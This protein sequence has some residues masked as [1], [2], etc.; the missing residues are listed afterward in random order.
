MNI[1][2][3][4]CTH[5]WIGC[6][7]N[8]I[9]K[10]NNLDLY[11]EWVGQMQARSF[12]GWI[13]VLSTLKICQSMYFDF[14]ENSTFKVFDPRG[15]EHFQSKPILVYFWN[16]CGKKYI[17]LKRVHWVYHTWF[18]LCFQWHQDSNHCG[19]NCFEST[20]ERGAS[21]KKWEMKET[22]FAAIRM[23]FGTSNL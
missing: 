21:P 18:Y 5:E 23:Y 9:L 19:L 20:R 22:Q 7:L 17:G 4:N 2:L 10:N 11:L 6:S 1:I 13:L 8:G 12:S 14:L 15:S 16:F 3:P